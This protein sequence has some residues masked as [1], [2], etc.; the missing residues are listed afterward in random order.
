MKN[1]LEKSTKLLDS[2]KT[3]INNN[4]D[5]QINYLIQQIKTTKIRYGNFD[6]NNNNNLNEI[7]ELINNKIEEIL[8][9][10]KGNKMIKSKKF[11]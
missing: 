8:I 5:K 6:D 2:L 3:S 9:D 10:Q 11:V 4:L 7:N 1:K